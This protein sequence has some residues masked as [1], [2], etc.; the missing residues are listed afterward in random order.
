MN[1]QNA[2][3][4]RAIELFG[5]DFSFREGQL[6]VVESIV[7]NATTNIKHTVLEAPTGSGKSFIAILAAYVLYKDYNMTSYIL[8]SDLS[9]FEQYEND[10]HQLLQ[11]ECFGYL[12]GKEN[13]ICEA[14]GCKVSQSLCSLQHMSIINAKYSSK[15]N[16]ICAWTCKYAHD[17]AKAVKSP[18]TLMT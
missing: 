5:K 8:V 15:N 12:K 2:I 9:L 13:Y 4:Q 14:N 6:D 11:P 17:Y 3:K 16:F 10:I 18:I 1:M 7:L